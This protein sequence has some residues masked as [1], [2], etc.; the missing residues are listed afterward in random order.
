MRDD[1]RMS[2]PSLDL[3]VITDLHYARA[4]GEPPE[5]PGRR[6]FLGPLLLRKALLRLKHQGVAPGAIVLLGDL[7]DDGMANDAEEHWAAIA[8]EAHEAKMPVLAVPGN[9]DVDP[10]RCARVF[11]CEPGLHEIG[12]Y[13]FMVFHD[14]VAAGDVTTRPDEVLALPRKAALAKP[15]LPLVALQHNPLHPPIEAEYPY[16]LTNATEIMSAY[17]EAGVLLSLSGHYH[18]GQPG[19]AVDGTT[20][21]TAPAAC[22][23][24][25]RFAWISLRGRHVAIREEAL[26]MSAP[27]LADVHCHTEYAYCGTTVRAEDN[28]RV[29]RAMGIERLYLTEHTFQLYFEKKEAWSWRWQTDEAMVERAWTSGRGRMRDFRRFAEAVRQEAVSVGN[30]V[31]LRADGSLLLAEEDRQGWDIIVGAV[32][33]IPAYR[34]GQTSQA[35]TEKLF[36]RQTEGLLRQPIHV[37]AHPF[38]FF[39]REGLVRPVHLYGPVAAMLA[40]SGVAA[41]VNFHTNQPDPRFLAECLARGVKLACGTDSHDLAEVG[42]FWPH[43]NVL[44]QAGVGDGSLKLFGG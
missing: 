40:R 2:E 25:F 17:K 44:R 7:V 34:K 19:H 28:I 35:E 24:P 14:R 4:A 22:E 27:G 41:E 1:S 15:G 18:P 26:Q 10:A 5:A 16:M 39:L 42:E 12:G 21:Y 8:A 33:A 11:G 13:G 37:L 23:A 36:L 3:L 29:S 31:D 6:T 32:H 20:Y 30:E 9:H 43:L 38:R